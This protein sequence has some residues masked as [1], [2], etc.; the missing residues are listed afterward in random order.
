MSISK[1]IIVA[2]TMGAMGNMQEQ[3]IYFAL[4][5]LHAKV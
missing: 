3:G 2:R 1:A 4:N 5:V